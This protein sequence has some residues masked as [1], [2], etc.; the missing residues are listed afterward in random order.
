MKFYFTAIMAATLFSFS[1]SANAKSLSETGASQGHDK[2]TFFTSAPQ[3]S[4]PLKST[5]AGTEKNR[6][7]FQSATKPTTGQGDLTNE[8]LNLINDGDVREILKNAGTS[9]TDQGNSEYAVTLDASDFN[10]PEKAATEVDR[11]GLPAIVAT[12]NM[13]AVLKLDRPWQGKA[14]SSNKPK[15]TNINVK[16]AQVEWGSLKFQ[17]SGDLSVDRLGRPNGSIQFIL[18]DWRNS[19]NLLPENEMIDRANLESAMEKAGSGTGI[20]FPVAIKNG[21][22]KIG[23]F[24]VAQIPPL[25]L[26]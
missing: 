23:P 9:V 18:P 24:T 14:L 17:A 25:V 6:L 5:S 2:S 10:L 19:L 22:A 26:Q 4:D 16:N 11:F 3:K 7:F 20:I 15:L 13:D 21:A 1:S 8:F 12:A